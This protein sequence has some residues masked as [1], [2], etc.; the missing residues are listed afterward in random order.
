MLY[1]QCPRKYWWQHIG[2]PDLRPPQTEE[3]IR[4]I[5]IH[6]TMETLILNPSNEDIVDETKAVAED[7]GVI[8]DVGFSTMQELMTDLYYELDGWECILNEQKLSA[9]HEQLDVVLVGA[10]DGLLRTSDDKVILVELKTGNFSDSKLSRTRRELCFYT[11]L[12][13]L[14][15]YPTP[16]HFLYVA[17]DALNEKTLNKLLAQKKKTVSLGLSQGLCLIE[18]I[19][20]RSMNAFNKALNK[21]LDG[22][23]NNDW[24]MNWNEF[25]CGQYC[26]YQ[27]Q[28]EPETMGLIEDVTKERLL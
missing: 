2:L 10:V 8:D 15:D 16:T 19:S 5:N 23:R 21:T 1:N 7:K 26:D 24:N 25:Y 27:T 13:G 3:M 18:P 6:S 17:P 9:Y 20:L 4:G 12:L 22:L 11:M 14:F 28:C